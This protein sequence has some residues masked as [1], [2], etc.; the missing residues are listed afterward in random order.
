[1]VKQDVRFLQERWEE[2]IH[3]G[4]LAMRDWPSLFNGSEGLER[5]CCAAVYE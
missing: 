1:M 4:T 2:I 5:R 3:N